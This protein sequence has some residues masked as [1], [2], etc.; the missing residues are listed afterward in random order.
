MYLR[1]QGDVKGLYEDC[2]GNMGLFLANADLGI[3]QHSARAYNESIT[4]EGR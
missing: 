3:D 2:N 4:S 1:F